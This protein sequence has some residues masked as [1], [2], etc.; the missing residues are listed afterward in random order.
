MSLAFRRIALIAMVCLGCAGPWL[1]AQSSVGSGEK[2]KFV[3]YLTRHGVRSPTGEASRYDPYSALPWPRWDVPPGYLT[4]HGYKLMTLYGAYDRAWFAQ[5]GLLAPS[6]CAEAAHVTILT[7]SDQR[8]RE[9]GK[10]LAEG[11]F[12]G[13]A[14]EV[15]ARPQGTRDPL[16]HSMGAAT[17]IGNPGLETAAIGGRIGGDPNNLTAAYHSQLTELERVLSGCGHAP[18]NAQKRTSLFDIPATLAPD[19]ENHPVEMRGPLNTASSLTENLLLEYTE[20]MPAADVG[21]GCVDDSTL[22]VLMELHSAAA[23]ITERTPAVA[24][25]LA[26]TLLTHILWAMEQQM[27]D[28]AV[29]GAPGKPGDRLLILVG[30]DTNIAA[31]SGALDLDW[32]LD[33]RRDD[34]PPG[35]ALIFEL[36]QSQSGAYSVRVE[37]AAQTLEQMRNAT[38]LTLSTPP[39][40]VPVFVPGCM[41]PNLSC[42][43]RTFRTILDRTT[44]AGQ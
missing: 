38:V 19:T 35:G 12:P 25:T 4:P 23:D 22:R 2:L 1:Q 21:W 7:D 30:H 20:G 10:A 32:I 16:F 29:L 3:V 39:D 41:N 42:A 37:Y 5:A 18:L 34:T 9:T 24:R 40:R 33:G 13:C 14:T 15:Q 17:G 6:G 36:W 26:G 8:T 28:R 11:M 44:E 27:T 43:W 31:V